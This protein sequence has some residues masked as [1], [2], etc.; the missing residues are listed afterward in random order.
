ML[1][2]TTKSAIEDNIS[3]VFYEI[4]KEISLE[5]LSLAH[6]LDA[7]IQECVPFKYHHIATMLK[8]SIGITVAPS[9]LQNI[10]FITSSKN[11]DIG[12]FKFFHQVNI[13]LLL[14]SYSLHKSYENKYSELCSCILLSPYRDTCP[15]CNR[16]FELPNM[17]WKKINVFLHNGTSKK[18][19][20]LSYRCN[21]G[22]CIIDVFPNFYRTDEVCISDME[23]FSNSLYYYY[24][25]ESA[26]EKSLLNQFGLL[27]SVSRTSFFGFS[28]VNNL[29]PGDQ[30]DG[31]L[32]RRKFEIDFLVYEWVKFS[33]FI[34]KQYVFTPRFSR[35]LDNKSFD[36][37]FKI[38]IQNSY[39]EF[40]R[41]WSKM[42]FSNTKCLIVDGTWKLRRAICSNKSVSQHSLAFGSIESS[43]PNTPAFKSIYCDECKPMFIDVSKTISKVSKARQRRLDRD[44]QRN[45]ILK[46][47]QQLSC[48]VRKDDILSVD[49][50]ERALGV[51]IVATDKNVIVA[52]QELLRTE[53]KKEV[54]D[55]LTRVY[56]CNEKLPRT[57]VYDAGCL[58]EQYVRNQWAKGS[59]KQ[60]TAT[61]IVANARYL[62]DRFHLVNHK[63]RRC[64]KELNPD[65]YEDMSGINTQACEE[66][67]KDLKYLA[68]ILNNTTYVRHKL[69]LLILSHYHNC[70]QL[71]LK[72]DLNM[73]FQI[74]IEHDELDTNTMEVDGIVCRCDFLSLQNDNQEDNSNEWTDD[75]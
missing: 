73:S 33:L 50:R 51:L 12:C 44:H 66:I 8:Q 40:T 18:G 28:K 19:T 49:L 4:T 11:Q 59:M 39:D 24:G 60:S 14:S 5:G 42:V 74:D 6:E 17:K 13:E 29:M 47:L 61:M 23:S 22:K 43:C 72:Y 56:K 34:G 31:Q 45:K 63:R 27:L 35:G 9:T 62:I 65:S 54:I 55:I 48:N 26:Y 10:L 37:Q 71:K 7:K 58:L 16:R 75:E 36:K 38:I 52:F 25:G 64:H 68:P 70:R 53:S 67:N 69:L 15:N 30:C 57:I 21:S 20:V 41:F 32:D 2:I 46:T 1:P 3:E